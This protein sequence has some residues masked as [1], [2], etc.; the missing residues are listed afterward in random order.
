MNPFVLIILDGFGIRKS[1]DGNAIAMAKTPHLDKIL[2]E[3][4]HTSLEASGEAVGLPPGI[5]G[6][7]EV[8]HLTIGSGR[9]VYQDLSRINHSIQ[10][11]SFFHLIGLLS[12]GGVHSHEEHLFALVQMAKKEKVPVVAIHCFL[13]GRDTPPSS[14]Q[15]YLKKLQ[16]EMKDF[17][18]ITT[19]IGRYYAMDRDKRWERVQ[20]AYE[21][22]V[23]GK[24]DV[25]QDPVKAVQEAYDQHVTDEF[26]KPLVFGGRIQDGDAGIFFN[27]RPDR[28][29][30][31]TQA[32]T[33]PNF[34]GFERKAWPQL[35]MFVCMTEYDQTYGLP[36]AFPPQK[37]KRVLAELLSEQGLAQFHTAETEKYAHVTYFLNGGIEP[38]FP[39][40]ERSLIP[41]PREVATYDKK[42]EMSAY[43]VTEGVLKKLEAG[44][45]VILMNFANP[46][47]VAHSG[48]LLA[49]IQAVEVIDGCIGKI[50]DQVLKQN[51]TVMITSDHGNCE[52]MKDEH[53]GP[54]TA[55]TTL[56]VPFILISDQY[57]TS[58]LRSGGGL[59]DVAPTIL[60]IL[61]IPQA[62]EMTGK[63][64]IIP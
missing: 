63:S 14:S 4:P 56:P 61:Q 49:T 13:D 23:E 8:G 35:G 48:V 55:H 62:P 38:P 32:L 47:M 22:L 11:G 30:E 44:C 52:Q 5:M 46:D 34:T 43:A 39:G 27:F 15:K 24:G 1:R 53:G 28:A 54:H 33:D 18:E 21:A 12:D 36:V 51:G 2:K 29:R 26:I 31:L 60:K 3:Y 58:K 45:P 20:I 7:S 59:Q 40:E 57:K 19:L 50:V 41:S 37:P 16:H 6:N 42:P 64:L 9:I 17:G 10:D 25:R